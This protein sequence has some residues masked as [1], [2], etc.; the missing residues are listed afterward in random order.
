MRR[1]FIY[2]SF[3]LLPFNISFSQNYAALH[4]VK[5][6]NSGL[7]ADATAFLSTVGG[8]NSIQQSAINTFVVQLKVKGLWAKMY[9]I[10]P[11][12]GTN[13]TQ[14]KWN[15][16]DLRDLDAAFRLTFSSTLPTFN[17]YGIDWPNSSSVYANTHFNLRNFDKNNFGVTTYVGKDTICKTIL[18][19]F[20]GATSFY[21]KEAGNRSFVMQLINQGVPDGTVPQPIFDYYNTSGTTTANRTSSTKLAIFRNGKKLGTDNTTTETANAPNANIYLNNIAAGQGGWNGFSRMQFVAIHQG[22]TDAE[23]GTFDTLVNNLQLALHRSFTPPPVYWFM[24]NSITWGQAATAHNFS[25]AG[26]VCNTKLAYEQNLAYP[27]Y[28]TANVIS[29]TL[30]LLP[31]K[32]YYD[33]YVFLSIGINDC[34]SEDTSVYRAN[35]ITIINSIKSKGYDSTNIIVP[36]IYWTPSK[37]TNVVRYNDVIKSLWNIYHLQIKPDVYQ[38]ILDNPHTSDLYNPDGI[39]PFN[40][41]HSTVATCILGS[42]PN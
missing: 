35:M 40:A 6:Y 27:A 8:A 21:L 38:A 5:L 11:L 33:K 16:K 19:A 10:Y 1:I 30:P 41:I 12:I 9:A 29:N 28:I 26:I 25:W 20:D 15:L 13:S 18:G 32:G 7:D 24:G 14:N 17:N 37:N 36:T 31:S 3:L 22:L 23:T 42:L 34:C 2:L 4:T 39:H